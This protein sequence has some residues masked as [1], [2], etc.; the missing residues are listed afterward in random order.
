[1][2]KLGYTLLALAALGWCYLIFREAS[3]EI[4]PEGAIGLLALGG[5]GVFFIK[6]VADRV[7]NKEDDHYDKN[8][9]K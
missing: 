4:F 1:M 8:V 3:L 2:E 9:E 7:K 6:A 5:C